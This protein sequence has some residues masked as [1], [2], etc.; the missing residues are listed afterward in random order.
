M[1]FSD[2]IKQAAFKGIIDRVK[3]VSYDSLSEWHSDT[4]K[5]TL[6]EQKINL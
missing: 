5:L 4:Y 6:T 3:F 1:E 2:A